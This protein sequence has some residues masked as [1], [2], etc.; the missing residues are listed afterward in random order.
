MNERY[1][2]LYLQQAKLSNSATLTIYDNYFVK[3]ITEN[4]ME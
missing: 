1:L 4:H 3:V 2:E